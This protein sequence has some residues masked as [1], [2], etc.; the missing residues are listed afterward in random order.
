MSSLLG[1]ATHLSRVR[2][3]LRSLAEREFLV[4][5]GESR[6]PGEDE[7]AFRHAL[8]REGAYTMLTEEDRKLGHRLAGEWLSAHG[9]PDALLLAEHFEKGGEREQAGRW[10]QRAAE[11]ATMGGDLTA[12]IVHAKRTLALATS[13]ELRIDAL[14]GLCMTHFYLFDR[15]ADALPFAEEVMQLAP[16]GSNAWSWGM[17]VLLR[18]MLAA[19][20]SDKFLAKIRE[21]RRIEPTA[22]MGAH[23]ALSLAVG[24]FIFDLQGP[25]EEADATM[26]RVRACAQIMRAREPMAAF[27]WLVTAGARAAHTLEE[28]EIGLHHNIEAEAISRAFGPPWFADSCLV[29]AA[30]DRWLLGQAEEAERALSASRAADEGFGY[31]APFRPFALAWM[32]AERGAFERAEEWARRLVQSGKSRTA[33]HDEGRGLWV[34]AEVLRRKGDLEA[35]DAAIH[36]ALPLLRA[37]SVHDIPGALGTLA[38]LRR[39]QGRL[40]DAVSA[41]EEGVALYDSTGRCGYFMRG[42]FLRLVYAECL[43]A[44]GDHAAASRALAE[45]RRC[46]LANAAK[47]REPVNRRSFLEG[48]PENRRTLELARRWLGEQA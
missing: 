22:E 12:S 10:Y 26:D 40:A 32:L 20:K 21:L 8:L 29:Y 45:A 37:A 38:A 47:I 1:G 24:V 18:C 25:V 7:Y 36:E 35:A 9:A 11:V 48:V 27:W 33:P 17:C 46:I 41:A 15:I 34:L 44:A 4:K 16:L 23:F 30:V 42:A 19:G 2:E 31:G 5:R 39:A 28:P 3:G 43:D 6:F 14:T 13:T